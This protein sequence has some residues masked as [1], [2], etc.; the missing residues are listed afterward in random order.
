MTIDPATLEILKNRF[1]AIAC[2]MG[3]VAMRSAYSTIIKEMQDISSSIFDTDLRLIAEGA[4]VP[5]H[6][7]MLKSCLQSIFDFHID[8]RDLQPGDVILTNDP[9]IGKNGASSG[10][11][12]TNDIVTVLP[13]FYQDKLICLSTIV[14]HHRDVGGAWPGTRGWNVEIW[15]EGTRVQPVKLIKKGILDR[16][17]FNLILNNS[18]VPYDMEGDISAQISGCEFGQNELIAVYHRYGVDTVKAA[19]DELINYSE[20]L[21]RAEIKKIK[22]GSYRAQTLVLDDGAYGGPHRLKVAVHVQDNNIHFDYSGT[23]P[24]IKGPI[25]APW[26]A[27]YSATHYVMRALTDPDIPTND[28]CS[29]PIHIT[30]PEGTL[31]NCSKPAACYQRMIV[32]HMIVDLIMGALKDVIPTR[33]MADSCGCIYNFA[34]AINQRTHPFGGEV[35]LP[36]Q[37]WGEVVPSGLGARFGKDGISAIAC[38]VTNVPIP[39]IEAAEIEAPVLYMMRELNPNSAGPGKFRGGFGQILKWKTLGEDNT[40]WLNYTA[41]KHHSKPQGFFGGKSGRSGRWIINEGM[42]GEQE[43]PYSIGDTI[44]LQTHDTLSFYGL[45]GGGYGEPLDRDPADVLADFRNELISIE[46][47]FVDYGVRINQA[48]FT[49]DMS[50]TQKERSRCKLKYDGENHEN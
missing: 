21:T 41:Q 50:A 27:T 39:P 35:A 11:H 18:R 38:H 16:D 22:N 40:T 6:L 23:D 3:Q 14:G 12:H 7:N 49:V 30:A 45:G 28:G 25:N 46:D 19:I 4:N 24:Q 37:V 8:I 1:Q 33:V 15:Q 48:D 29:K 13:V 9:Y 36:R 44:T 5:I 34:S 31:V 2:Q 26:A 17:V 42:E 32:C 47:A 43:L 10:T 20:R